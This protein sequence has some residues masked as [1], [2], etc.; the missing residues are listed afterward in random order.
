MATVPRFAGPSSVL[1]EASG[2]IIQ[3]IRKPSEFKIN[4]YAQYIQTPTTN[5]VYWL[6][7]SYSGRRITSDALYAWEDGDHRPTGNWQDMTFDSVN[8]RTQRRTYPATVGDITQ[9]VNKSINKIDWIQQKT[10][11]VASKAMVNRTNRAIAELQDTANWGDNTA[12]CN[13]INGGYGPWSSASDDPA[14]PN[15]LAIKRS[16]VNAA[17]QITLLTDGQ[18]K[19]KDLRLIVSPGLAAIMGNTAE[20]YN[21]V[22]FGPAA[23]GRQT[24]DSVDYSEVYGL[25]NKLYG[26]D[27]IVEDASIT[28]VP[29][30]G[31][32]SAP[33]ITTGQ[34]AYIK[35]DTTAIL[36][37]QAGGIEG[38]YGAPAFSTFQ[39]YFYGAPMEAE[40]FNSP[41]DRL[42]EVYLTENYF[43]KLAAPAS[44]FL[45]TSCV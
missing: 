30:N 9:E 40:S 32:G 33:S 6:I 14:S 42:T 43:E 28:T 13:T 25:P 19:L 4:K 38:N 11:M 35:N 7:D 16:I 18:V 24:G 27:V 8:F 21:Y 20:I 39:I 3:Y 1:Y 10:G 37:S 5:G 31:D 15:F 34:L 44:G 17:A 23:L 2:Q 26:V 45:F 41:K 12:N 22:R 36:C 29:Q